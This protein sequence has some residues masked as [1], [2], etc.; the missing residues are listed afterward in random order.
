MP[1]SQIHVG[2][3]TDPERYVAT[4]DAVWFGEVSAAPTEEQLV[5]L[6]AE[7]RFAAHLDGGRRWHVRGRLRGLSADPVGARTRGEAC[8]SC[9]LPGL[10]WVGVHPDHRR[11]GV[12]T[13]MMRHHLEQVREEQG[14]HLS[15]LHASEPAI[16]GRYGYGLASLELEVSLGRGTR[17]VSPELEDAA[18]ALGTSLA[19]ASDPGM[20]AR[21]W[22]CHLQAADLG[23]VVGA[24]GYYD[25]ICRQLPEHLRDKEPWRVLFRSP[26]RQ[27]RGLRDVSPHA[28]VGASTSIRRTRSPAAR[29]VIRRPARAAASLVDYDLIATV[30]VGGVGTDDPLLAWVG[31]PRAASDVAIYDSLWVRLVD[32]PDALQERSWGP[33]CDVVVQVADA[34]A[35]WNA[36]A[37]RIHS[38]AAGAATVEPTAAAADLSLGVEALGAAYLGGS[39]LVAMNRA[40]LI[41]EH[42][43]G[44]VAELWRAMRT[45]VA[46]AAAIEF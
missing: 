15:V 11:K 2:R 27:G 35:P 9:R 41:V 20:P 23:S 13:A 14:T 28:Q 10:T 17:L 21:L 3:A 19:T 46:P 25:R 36:G 34:F 26:R 38:D 1:Q 32:V 22:T 30:K 31:G 43:G 39:N 37:W 42:R 8:G 44:A 18:A 5:G 12:L 6:S 33:A 29:R 45:D 16:Y 24:L 7:H 4:D 40:G